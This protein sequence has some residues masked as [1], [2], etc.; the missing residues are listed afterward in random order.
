MDRTHTKTTPSKLGWDDLNSLERTSVMEFVRSVADLR[1]KQGNQLTLGGYLDEF[2][3]G[4]R[5][6]TKELDSEIDD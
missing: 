1:E 6:A 3:R 2:R 4:L 5:D